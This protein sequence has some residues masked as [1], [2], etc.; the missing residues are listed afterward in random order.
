MFISNEPTKAG[1]SGAMYSN[2]KDYVRALYPNGV[3]E[4]DWDRLEVRND[5]ISKLW[6]MNQLPLT[7]YADREEE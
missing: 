2:F 6:S 7:Q 3:E 4:E 5:F 1:E